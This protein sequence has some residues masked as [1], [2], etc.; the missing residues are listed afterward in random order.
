MVILR[1]G[2][3]L[4]AL[5][6]LVALL[7]DFEGKLNTAKWAKMTKVSQDT[8]GRDINELLALGILE[9]DAAGGRSTSY[10]LKEE[11]HNARPGTN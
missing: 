7:G 10:K 6:V 2:F 3:G 9:K 11:N 5:A 8:A 1:T 4:I